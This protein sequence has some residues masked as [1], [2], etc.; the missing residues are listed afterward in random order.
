[1]I[2]YALLTS[3]AFTAPA[4]AADTPVDDE[5]VEGTDEGLVPTGRERPAERPRVEPT[6]TTPE[7][8][9]PD[10]AP[11]ARRTVEAFEGKWETAGISTDEAGNPVQVTA[12]MVCE[13][14]AAGTAVACDSVTVHADGKHELSHV[15]Y[16]V[17]P[18]TAE[19]QR[20]SIT[21]VGIETDTGKWVGDA[22]I[23]ETG[24]AGEVGTESTTVRV[25]D[26]GTMQERTVRKT[27]QGEEIVGETTG[28]R[29]TGPELPMNDRDLPEPMMQPPAGDQGTMR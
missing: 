8:A 4:L 7:L 9:K 21:E 1:M 17:A 22:L 2:R 16:G 29:D 13:P 18:E 23:I 15:V 12:T 26:D 24:P 5:P 20:V 11:E 10:V 27:A 19:V 28:K 3:L 14:I 6:P 25:S